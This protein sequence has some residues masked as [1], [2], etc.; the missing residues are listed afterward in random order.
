MIHLTSPSLL[1]RWPSDEALTLYQQQVARL[2]REQREHQR[3]GEQRSRAENERTKQNEKEREKQLQIQRQAKEEFSRWWHANDT[4]CRRWAEQVHPPLPS[5]HTINN[6]PDATGRKDNQVEA[7]QKHADRPDEDGMD[8]DMDIDIDVD[9]DESQARYMDRHCDVNRHPSTQ[10]QPLP[11][12]PARRAP[13]DRDCECDRD[14]D[15]ANMDADAGHQQPT[16]TLSNHPFYANANA[17]KNRDE[18]PAK[19][20]ARAGIE[21]G[22]ETPMI[23][24]ANTP[25]SGILAPQPRRGVDIRGMEMMMMMME[26]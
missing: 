17:H 18:A 7:V 3:Q 14:N 23:I 15:Q 5:T 11:L 25:K 1:A 6:K 12:R 26:E 19:T 8:V 2:E 22:P 16:L 21:V 9:I 24:A 20:E 10:G 13:R 4:K